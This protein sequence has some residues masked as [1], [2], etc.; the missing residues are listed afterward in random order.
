MIWATKKLLGALAK[1]FNDQI[2]VVAK[3]QE[4][5]VFQVVRDL[6]VRTLLFGSIVL[7][8]V[9]LAAFLI[10]RSLT[11][12]IN[13]LVDG[14]DAVSRGDL[15]TNIQLK[16]RDETVTLAKS[17]NQ[18]ISDLK[19]SR[20]ALQDMNRE[21]DKKK[22]RTEQLAEQNKKVKEVQEALIRTTRLASLGEL[23]GRTAHEVLNPLTILL[24]RA[25]L[26][27][28]KVSPD[29]QLQVVQEIQRAWSKDY[30]DG[31]FDKLVES[32]K[33]PSTVY[34]E[35]NLFQE[36]LE[37]LNQVSAHL[38]TQQKSVA[39]DM[40]FIREEGERIGKIINGMRRLGHLKTD[41]KP[42]DLHAIL[43]DCCQIM[44]DLFIE[45]G[46]NIETAF[47]AKD[48]ICVVDRDEIVQTVTNLMRNS[49]HALEVARLFG[50]PS[51]H[52]ARTHRDPG[53]RSHHRH[54][55][56]WRRH[57]AGRSGSSV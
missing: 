34:P 17:F 1:G 14:M 53:P 48:P 54:R 52:N 20:D 10:S 43:S 46:C 32:W 37:N 3:A 38:N 7:T 21:L 40:Q 29:A 12:N 47:T 31:G 51:A 11:E 26:V 42:N 9:I 57:R 13:R 27:Q 55:R 24:T 18:M 2:V 50:W 41:A 35:K 49:L 39:S 28:K 15:T 23:A 19:H 4:S 30:Q 16:G 44:H 36:D 8:L 56:Q 45:K 5:Q 22:E 25:G 33:S 6:T